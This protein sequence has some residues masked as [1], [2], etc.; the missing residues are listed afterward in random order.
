MIDLRSDTVT[1]PTKEMRE[2]MAHAVVG[3]EQKREDPTVSELEE[4]AAELLGHESSTF[5]P[6][7]TMANQIALRALTEPG[8]EAIVHANAHI[9]R[10]ESGGAAFHSGVTIKP[11]NGERGIFNADALRCAVNPNTPRYAHTSIVCIEN[12]HNCGGGK[13]WPLED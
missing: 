11:L 1:E 6:T 4:R 10:A 7:A 5:L 8:D 3:D 9:V 2:A 12:T 13:I